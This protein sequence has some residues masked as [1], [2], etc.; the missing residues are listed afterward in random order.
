MH[1]LDGSKRP[2]LMF[3]T[4]SSSS[5]N[6]GASS[7]GACVQCVSRVEKGGSTAQQTSSCMLTFLAWSS[8]LISS[9]VTRRTVTF[10]TS[11]LR[12]VQDF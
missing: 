1:Q 5:S 6:P 4:P 9:S 8:A 3:A 12:S 2:G 11:L 10:L 7:C